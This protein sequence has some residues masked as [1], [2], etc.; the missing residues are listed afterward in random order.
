MN[1]NIEQ[2]NLLRGQAEETRVQELYLEL[3]MLIPS[4][5][6]FFFL[7]TTENSFLTLILYQLILFSIPLIYLKFVTES[8]IISFF[9]SNFFFNWRKQLVYGILLNFLAFSISYSLFIWLLTTNTH[10]FIEYDLLLPLNQP[11]YVS[12][13]FFIALLNPFLSEIYWRIIPLSTQKKPNKL[14]LAF[15]YGLFH[16]FIVYKLKDSL[17]GMLFVVIYMIFGGI[18]TFIKEKIGALTAAL[19]HMG[20]NLTYSLAFILIIRE[21]KRFF[22]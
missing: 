3:I 10:Y 8:N 5:I 20:V 14:R 21:Q 12:L 22:S 11:I 7:Y 18:L 17:N 4:L 1:N 13:F 9:S 2:Q 6:I 15:F 16:G 19:T